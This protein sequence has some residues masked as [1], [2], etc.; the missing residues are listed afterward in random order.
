MTWQ[1]IILL[2]NQ[3]QCTLGFEPADGG[4]IEG[5]IE[6]ALVLRA[7]TVFDHKRERLAGRE[8]GEADDQCLSFSRKNWWP[9][10]FFLD[11]QL[12]LMTIQTHMHLI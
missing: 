12:L 3:S 1:L 5:V 4:F 8:L 7:I 6:R 2:P 9:R 11:L 10:A